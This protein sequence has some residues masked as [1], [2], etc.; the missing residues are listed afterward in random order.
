MYKIILSEYPLEFDV[1]LLFSHYRVLRTLYATVTLVDVV[2]LNRASPT[3][4]EARHVLEIV[5]G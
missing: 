5:L 3:S 1:E 4:S 2:K